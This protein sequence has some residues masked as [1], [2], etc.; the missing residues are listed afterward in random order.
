MP[1]GSICGSRV[2]YAG[3]GRCL[4]CAAPGYYSQCRSDTT[5]TSNNMLS[6]NMLLVAG[7]MLPVS[8]QHVSLCIQQQ[9][10]N[11]LATVLLPSTCCY[12]QDVDGNRQHIA[13]N[14][15]PGNMLPW[16][17]RGFIKCLVSRLMRSWHRSF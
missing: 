11:K 14:M 3:Y 2:R 15:L 5:S 16:H 7:N 8:R 12:K 13:R 17:K 6:G 1:A 4:T 9:T 10:S